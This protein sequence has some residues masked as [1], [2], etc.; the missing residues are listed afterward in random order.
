M[1]Q[2]SS[3][4]FGPGQQDSGKGDG[5][6]GMG[7]LDPEPLPEVLSNRDASRHSEQRGLDS[8]HLRAERQADR[9]TGGARPEGDLADTRPE[10]G[11]E[12]P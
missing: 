10:D 2:A 9:Q 7:P 12:T 3:K 11:K 1:A 6:G 5:T 4:K 8:A